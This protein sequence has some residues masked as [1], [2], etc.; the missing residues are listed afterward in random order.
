MFELPADSHFSKLMLRHSVASAVPEERQ[1]PV[2]P[3]GMA[4]GFV[5]LGASSFEKL[6]GGFDFVMKLLYV[7]ERV[8][9][10]DGALAVKALLRWPFSQAY[11]R[12]TPIL[13]D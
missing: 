6:P 9:E 8:Q 7:D 3:S 5:P 11:S 12:R 1:D 2:G 10:S 13:V 4:F